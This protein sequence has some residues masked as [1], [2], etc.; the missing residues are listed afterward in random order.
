VLPV[1]VYAF[2]YWVHLRHLFGL[3]GAKSSWVDGLNGVVTYAVGSP[4][5]PVLAWGIVVLGLIVGGAR[6]WERR[7]DL[8]IFALFTVVL[9]PTLTVLVRQPEFVAPRYF[10]SAL[11]VVFVCMALAIASWTRSPHLFVRGLCVGYVGLLLVGNARLTYELVS[12]GRGDYRGALEMIANQSMAAPITAAT[13]SREGRVLLVLEHY[14]PQLPGQP[15]LVFVPKYLRGWSNA[16]WLIAETVA[17]TPDAT[18]A[19]GYSIRGVFPSIAL[20][21]LTWHV[22]QRTET[23][24]HLN[25]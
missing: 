5:W 11:P 22:Y 17:R 6:L 13:T 10:L 2:V 16:Q 1:G 24:T 18:V 20:S 3:G 7:P 14:A 4:H 25:G 15:R 8:T 12:V 19:P 23:P 21:G 9:A